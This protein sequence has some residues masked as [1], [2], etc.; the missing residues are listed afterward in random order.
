MLIATHQ[1]T[2]PPLQETAA[3]QG[4]LWCRIVRATHQPTH[5]NARDRP[6]NIIKRKKEIYC[7][8]QIRRGE[9]TAIPRLPLQRKSGRVMP[10][11]SGTTST[12]KKVDRLD[13]ER[14]FGKMRARDDVSF[15]DLLARTKQFSSIWSAP[16]GRPAKTGNLRKLRPFGST[17]VRIWTKLVP[18]RRA[19]PS[20]TQGPS[21]KPTGRSA[22]RTSKKP[23]N[24]R[25][26]GDRSRKPGLRRAGTLAASGGG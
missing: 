5:P 12:R 17:R 9:R 20:E 15:A 19:S 1:P 18:C 13:A 4:F 7:P 23:A 2:H 14:A 24:G 21:L 26:I 6:K 11:S 8:F 3:A 25:G 16:S 10:S 22:S